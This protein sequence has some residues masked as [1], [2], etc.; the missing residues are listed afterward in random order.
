MHTADLPLLRDATAADIPAL[1]ALI[2][3]HG[4]NPWNYLPEEEV[5]AHLDGIA[6]GSTRAVVAEQG[7][8]LIGLASFQIIRR[9]PRYERAPHGYIAE[10]VVH[11]DHAGRGIGS[12]LLEA[13]RQ[14]LQ[15]L[16]VARIYIDRHEENRASAGMMRKAGFVEVET[17]PDPERRSSGSRRTTVCR[18][19]G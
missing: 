15:A 10:V 9:F 4:P 11:R 14:R 3:A 5:N 8:T 18:W 13:C 7:G 12:A 1:K 19:A 6:D 17:F 16:G 2:F